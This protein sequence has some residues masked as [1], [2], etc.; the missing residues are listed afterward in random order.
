VFNGAL[1]YTPGGAPLVLAKAESY[2]QGCYAR[3]GAFAQLFDANEFFDLDNVTLRFVPNAE[4]G[5][6]VTRTTGAAIQPAAHG[7]LGLGDDTMAVQWLPFVFPYPGGE[8]ASIRICSN[9]YLWLQP[10]S[11][12]DYTPTM[13][14]LADEPPRIAMAWMDF[15]PGAPGSG[16]A[17]YERDPADLF[18]TITF[19]D[20]W[21]HGTFGGSLS[22]FQTVLYPSGEFIIRLGSVSRHGKPCIVGFSPGDGNLGTTPSSTDLSTAL[23][24]QTAFSHPLTLTAGPRPAPGATVAFRTLHVPAN[25]LHVFNLMSIVPIEPGIDLGSLG[26]PGCRHLVMSEQ[27][28]T[29]SGDFSRTLGPLPFG[30]AYVGLPVV[31]QSAC[32]VLGLNSLGLITS[33]AVRVTLGEL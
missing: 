29:L 33:N 14:E 15:N 4:G 10:S 25:A 31:S 5:Y 30:S 16:S 21:E 11:V 20:V 1:H 27:A 12:S 23:P 7:A 9:G 8:T 2:G 6:D 3:P 19:D 26:A 32:M 24:A 18:V 17:F 13:R 22:T 28:V